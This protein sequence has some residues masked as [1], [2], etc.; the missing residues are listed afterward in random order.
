MPAQACGST[1]SPSSTVL[2]GSWR[3]AEHRGILSAAYH[4]NVE[5]VEGALFATFAQFRQW[6]GGTEARNGLVHYPLAADD[7]E[8][9]KGQPLV[10]D[11]ERNDVFF[12]LAVGDLDVPLRGGR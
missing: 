2:D 3:A 9:V 4:Y 12:R 8:F 11:T 10:W 5:S 6:Q 1:T 7:Q